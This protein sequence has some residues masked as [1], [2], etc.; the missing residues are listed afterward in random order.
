MSPCFDDIVVV[1]GALYST[2]ALVTP[3]VAITQFK[4]LKK[5]LGAVIG[6]VAAIAV[7]FIAPAI[8]AALGGGFFASVIGQGLI[9]AGIGA[10]GGAAGAAVGGG[11]ILQGALMG[12]LGG[13]LG[14]A[15]KALFTPGSGMLSGTTAGFVGPPAPSVGASLLGNAGAAV[16]AGT[17]ATG[18]QS[19]LAGFG[20]V[21]TDALLQAAPNVAGSMYSQLTGGQQE[22]VLKELEAQMAIS[23]QSDLAA[24]NKQKELYDLLFN[25][26]SGIDPEYYGRLAEVD[27]SRATAAKLSEAKREMAMAGKDANKA[28]GEGE[29][30]RAAVEGTLGQNT[31]YREGRDKAFETKTAGLGNLKFPEY[32][33]SGYMRGLASLY[34]IYEG[35]SAADAK[36]VSQLLTPF[37][38]AFMSD[39][40]RKLYS[41]AKI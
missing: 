9:G 30:R 33:N 37:T 24:Y 20:G 3:S 22:Q 12:G 16:G 17:T 41:N 7:P 26:Y 31:A 19:A 36:G 25:T 21:T 5:I 13:A 8:G 4:G 2:T 28:Y 6:V 10:L 35:Q 27:Y 34:D 39:A 29:E 1:R 40:G 32:D 15:G 14:G 11:N 18:V 23:Q 38:Y